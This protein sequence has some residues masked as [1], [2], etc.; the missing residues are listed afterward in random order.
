MLR[1]RSHDEIRDQID[2]L[3]IDFKDYKHLIAGTCEV[4]FG[5]PLENIKFLSKYTE[6]MNKRFT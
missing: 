5:T 1:S 4:L 6:K 3:F 2:K